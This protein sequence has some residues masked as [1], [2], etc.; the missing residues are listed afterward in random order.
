LK[1]G[2]GIKNFEERKRERWK[3]KS[4]GWTK[5]KRKRN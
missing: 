3:V 1:K 2:K 4:P 5:R